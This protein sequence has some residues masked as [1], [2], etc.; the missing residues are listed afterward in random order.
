M[1]GVGRPCAADA[2]EDMQPCS[3]KTLLIAAL[4]SKDQGCKACH[5][6]HAAVK[7][8]YVFVL[9]SKPRMT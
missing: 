4:L 9:G 7:H 8:K 3:V 6:Y 5:G 1:P 2:Y